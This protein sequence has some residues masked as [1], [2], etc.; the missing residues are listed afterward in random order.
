MLPQRFYNPQQSRRGDAHV[1]AMRSR[2]IPASVAATFAHQT[3]SDG[4]SSATVGRA[5][6]VTVDVGG[7][8]RGMW[9][10]TGS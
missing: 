7:R 9:R 10:Q 4:L 3:W 5:P 2:F 6:T 1:Y 8:L